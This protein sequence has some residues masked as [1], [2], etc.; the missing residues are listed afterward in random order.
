VIVF[1]GCINNNNIIIVGERSS[2]HSAFQPINVNL[3]P[4]G[5]WLSLACCASDDD[6]GAASSIQN[7][8]GYS[9]PSINLIVTL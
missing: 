2:V 5:P 4:S 1:C 7:G 6:R 9:F 3:D 8:M